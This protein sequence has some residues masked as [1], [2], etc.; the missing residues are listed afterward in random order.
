MAIKVVKFGGSSLADASQ[1][2]KVK[3]IITADPARRYV[4]PSAPGKRFSDDIKVTDLLY[5]CY[6][7]RDDRE[8]FEKTF[9]LIRN[10]YLEIE[11]DLNVDAG[12]AKALDDVKYEMLFQSSS[13]YAASRGEY[14]N[15]RIMAAYLGYTFVD[16]ASVIV[17]DEDG[18]FNPALTQTAIS[19]KM[20]N[21]THAVVPGFYGATP[22][23]RIVTFSRGGSDITGSLVAAGVKADEYE[24]WTDV[25]GCL[26]ADPRV[27]KG[28][29]PIGVVTYNELRE[30]AYMGATVMHEDAIY[31]AR[32]ANIPIHIK[33]TN[34]P[35][36]AGTLIVSR[37][38]KD[39]I[40]SRGV[41]TGIAGKKGFCIITL[42]KNMLHNEIGFG[43]RA[44]SVLELHHLSFE[45]MP[46]GIDTLSLV[47]DEKTIPDMERLLADL[48]HA[49]NTD[50][51]E[52]VHD[53]SL[54]AVVGLG[55]AGNKG[56][57][58]RLFAALAEADVNIRMIDQGSSEMNIILAVDDT[59]YDAT[60]RAAYEAFVK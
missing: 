55:M 39:E 5:R 14:L 27:V 21:I 42:E 41:V 44:L 26:M 8:T 3:D 40:L 7:A 53:I 6:N 58:A 36:D 31:P 9:E 34:A 35:D 15:G 4:V 48:T 24:N 59:D 11:R 38:K 54:I 25:S 45:H 30:L 20:E 28:A 23:G 22:S 18:T 32:Q 60:I 49:C 12:M 1:F 10:R 13:D 17:F 43:R 46:S 57:A 37:I 33:N 56:T 51:I 47:I 2:A 16:A 19:C 29:K 52:I 50:S